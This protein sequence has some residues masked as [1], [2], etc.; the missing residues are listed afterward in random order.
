V[1]DVGFSI[2]RRITGADYLS[3]SAALLGFASILLIILDHELLAVVAL[4]L[5]AISDYVDGRMARSL[6]GGHEWGKNIDSLCDVAAFGV[7]PAFLSWFIIFNGLLDFNQTIALVAGFVFPALLI[8]GGILR[9]ARY[10]ISTMHR[11]YVGMPITMNGIIFP[12]AWAATLW[13]S[14]ELRAAVLILTCLVSFILMVNDF[15]IR[16]R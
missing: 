9:L 12:I 6:G 13:L 16:K 2:F 3:L 4:V 1:I 15:I 8:A 14:A 10:N 7:A 5:A 11:L